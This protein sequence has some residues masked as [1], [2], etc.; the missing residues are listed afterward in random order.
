MDR[1][2][3]R[4]FA[5]QD[6]SYGDF[7]SKLMPGYDRKRII[8]VRTPLL[9]KLAKELAREEKRGES[10]AVTEFLRSLPH[11]YYEEDNLHAYLIGEMAKNFDEALVM[12]EA[13]LPYIDNW[14]S[15][16]TFAP[17]IFKKDLNRLYEKSLLWLESPHTYTVR[18]AIVTQLTYFL[19]DSAFRPEV[20][21]KLARL[22]REEYY[23][24]MAIAWYYSYALIKQYE[25][26]I[27]L[28]EA[29]ILDKWLHNKSIQKALESYRIEKER[30]DYLRS[31]K[32]K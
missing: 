31:L 11:T 29:K 3:D 27:P 19:E 26:T 1:I 28:F 12:T 13:F 16:D 21:E 7:H 30:K 15:C 4:L 9:R 25:T 22:N 10:E 2:I 20:L 17:K 8:G 18:Y 23:I 14:A 32:L 6:I 5:L 24:N